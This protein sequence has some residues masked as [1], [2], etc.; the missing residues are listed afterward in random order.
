MAE[1]RILVMNKTYGYHEEH[2]PTDDTFVLKGLTMGGDI[3]MASNNI[4]GLP[5][6]P[7]GSTAATSKAYVDNKISGLQWR[8]PVVVPQLLGNVNCLGLV[9]NA[10]A[11]VIEGLTPAEGDAYVVTMADGTGALATAT[12]GDVWQYV[13]AAWVKL[14]TGSGGFVPA[15]FYALLSTS[16]ALISPY[17]DGTD[18]GKRAY[19]DGTTNTGALTTPA[20]GDSY[21]IGNTGAKWLGSIYEWSGT[22]WTS[23]LAGSGGYVPAGTRAILALAPSKVLIAPYTDAT[24]DGKIVSFSGS[25]NTGTDTGEATDGSAVLS[26]GENSYYENWGFVYDGTVPTGTWVQFTGAGQINAGDGL[27]KS[28]NT[29]AVGKGDGIA[30]G[31]DDVA[32]DLAATDPGLELTGTSPNKKLRVLVDGAHGIVRGASGI[33]LEIDDTPDTLD[34][35]GDGLR[36]VGLPSLFKVNGTAVG[37]G[38]TAPNLDTLTN[39]S[40]ADLLHVHA[41]APATEAPKVEATH[42]NS[43]TISAGNAVR[44]SS[45]ANQ[46]AKGDNNNATNSRVIGI[47]RTGGGAD[48]GTSEVVK[49]GVATSVVSGKTANTPLFLGSAGALVEWAS[50]PVPGRV[51]RMGYAVNATD[52]DVQIADLGWRAI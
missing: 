34:V 16:T 8:T 7:S 30:V 42:V 32:V 27:T 36:V 49:C 51:V 50:L 18:D 21:V 5:A 13:S 44:W 22:A 35:D 29:L 10:A 38:V 52:V 45:T 40:N 28:G 3:L 20:T 48:P 37:A 17:T 19:F 25:S 9:G 31:A 12:V 11:S 2:D 26:E 41:A 43:E 14:A 1:R 46:I 4:T 23:I 47:A 6:I 39:G 15:G 33:E 24:D